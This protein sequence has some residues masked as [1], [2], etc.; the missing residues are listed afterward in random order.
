MKK[1]RVSELGNPIIFTPQAYTKRPIDE[2]AYFG[3]HELLPGLRGV[4]RVKARRG[5]REIFCAGRIRSFLSPAL[6]REEAEIGS[7]RGR[8]A[9]SASCGA[10]RGA[11]TTTTTVTP[12]AYRIEF[13][14]VRCTCW[15]GHQYHCQR[16]SARELAPRQVN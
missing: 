1:T 15:P 6:A 13:G 7:L 2:R 16:A 9:R 14:F 12:I 8:G 3:M 5:R 4:P 11:S 10:T